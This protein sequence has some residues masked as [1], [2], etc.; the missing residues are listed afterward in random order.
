MS[1]LVYS[2]GGPRLRLPASLGP[3]QRPPFLVRASGSAAAA[4]AARHRHLLTVVY[5]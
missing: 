4:V 2:G 1:G 3:H 5:V